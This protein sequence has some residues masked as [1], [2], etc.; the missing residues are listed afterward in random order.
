MNPGT[1]DR[2]IQVR[3]AAIAAGPRGA[4]ET[5][6]DHGAPVWAAR[7]DI[8]DRE[9]LRAAQAEASVTT[10]FV[11]RW[12]D[13]AAGITAADALLCEGRLYVIRGIRERGRRAWIE[14]SA[15]AGTA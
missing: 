2:R 8:S 1:L 3:R 15:E 12:S 9:R 13:F 4:V 14:I 5:W 11:L 6:A 10:R 7:R